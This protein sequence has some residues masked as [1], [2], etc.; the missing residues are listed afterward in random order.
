MAKKS[1]TKQVRD[2]DEDD[3][4]DFEDSDDGVSTGKKA[5]AD[6]YTGLVVITTLC[7]IAAA[8]LF[9]MDGDKYA[10]AKDANPIVAP[11]ALVVPPATKG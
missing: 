9:Y 11:N 7:L 5:G 6:A 2:D 4:E 1:K 3:L 10:N 8:V